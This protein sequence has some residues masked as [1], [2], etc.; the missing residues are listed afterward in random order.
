MNKLFVAVCIVLTFCACKE[1]NS[2][3]SFTINAQV[4][5]ITNQ[6]AFLEQ[7]YFSEKAPEVIDTAEVV[8]GKFVLHGKATEDGLFRIRFEQQ[9]MGYIFIND[10][11]VI[12][13]SADANNTNIDGANF[14]SKANQSFKQFL[15]GFNNQQMALNKL[16]QEI[17]SL[18]KTSKNDSLKNAK[19]AQFTSSLER[20]KTYVVKAVDS[21][22]HPVICMFA[23]GYTRGIDPKQVE[24][25]VAKLTS[26]FPNHNGLKEVTAQYNKMLAEA[27][28]PKPAAN[29]AQQQ[30]NNN[31]IAVGNVAPE[32]SMADTTG[33]PFN[34][35]SLK[36]KYVL[37]DFWASWC[38]PCRAE[39][40]NVLA[41]Y[42]KFK[43]KNFTVL[44]VSL[45]MDAAAWKKA[46][47]KD[48]LV[49]KQISDVKGWDC[50]A[51]KTYGF[52]AI[53]FNV[54]LDP[55]GKIIAKDL[56]EQN[57]GLKLAEVLK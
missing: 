47:V 30:F 7:L 48:K 5:N 19:T 14:E 56:R 45:D 51:T 6:K 31:S 39:N 33:A 9:Q 1:T 10:K 55:T 8:D 28:N 49:F 57:L 23:L 21:M 37:V 25:V 42:E 46:I 17:D 40:P 34:L 15:T 11:A 35:S 20:A 3:G 54:L 43:N 16:S 18:G 29:T 13:F 12:D 52:D 26:R 41:N 24:P 50:A 32:I 38:M 36:G 2:D 22:E 27:K 53:P 44:G 4:K